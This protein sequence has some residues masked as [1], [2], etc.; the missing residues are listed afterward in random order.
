MDVVGQ[1]TTHETTLPPP[2]TLRGAAECLKLMGHPVRL[3]LAWLLEL[4]GAMPV[5]DLAA[6]VGVS[7]HQTCE[8]LRLMQRQ[9]L[10]DARRNGRS[11]RYRIV[12]PRLSRLLACIE[13]H[14]PADDAG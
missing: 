4:R 1:S 10:L 6:A 5:K 13:A 14:C 9:G 11:V 3:Q 2:A 8:H 12:A 7:P